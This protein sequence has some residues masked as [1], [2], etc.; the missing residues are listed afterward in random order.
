MTGSANPVCRDTD[1]PGYAQGVPRLDPV[2]AEGGSS[3]E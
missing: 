2:Q 3:V 1:A